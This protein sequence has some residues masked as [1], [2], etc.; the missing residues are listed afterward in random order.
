MK[1]LLFF[2]CISFFSAAQHLE[3]GPLTRNFHLLEKKAQLKSGSQSI[4][5][6]FIY[7]SDTLSLPIF[8]EFSSNKFQEYTAQFNDPGVTNQLFYR[9]LDPNTLQPFPSSSTIQ[10]SLRKNPLLNAMFCYI[11]DGL[12]FAQ[13]Q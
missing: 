2:C 5:S 3:I 10:I 8:D 9:L 11:C 7:L 13:H 4:D 12:V 1:N 6:T